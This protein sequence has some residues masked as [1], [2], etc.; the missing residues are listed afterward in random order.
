MGD[1]QES[2][3]KKKFVELYEKHKLSPTEELIFKPQK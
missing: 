3:Q 1:V 2:K